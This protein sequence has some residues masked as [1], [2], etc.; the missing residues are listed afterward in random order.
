M[1]QEHKPQ[2]PKLILFV[3]TKSECDNIVRPVLEELGLF[4]RD[5]IWIATTGVGKVNATKTA[6]VVLSSALS[7]NPKAAQDIL[8]V[9]VGVCGGNELA[10]KSK[11]V[12]IHSVVN[13]DFD[14]SAVDG[15]AFVQP[16]FDIAVGAN[17][18]NVCLT[19]DHFCVDPAELPDDGSPYYCDM[20]LYGIASVCSQYQVRLAA[21]KAVSDVV[22]HS[23]QSE[24]YATGF[25]EAC[26]NAVQLL[27]AYL[28][29]GVDIPAFGV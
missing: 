27:V 7:I 28:K 10:A 13:A 8:C 25:D 1:K 15:D 14:T 17:P 21:L 29:S 9:N 20:E 2:F 11:A 3:A 4:G 24:E 6:C 12:Q 26:K 22:G 5:D 18:S 23:N 16:R 19:R